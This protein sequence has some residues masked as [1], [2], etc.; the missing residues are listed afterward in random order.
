MRKKRFNKVKPTKLQKK[1]LLIKKE[2]PD[3]PLGKAMIKAGYSKKTAKAPKQNF[4]ARRGTQ[5]AIEKWREMLRE[6]G[7]GE[8]T[9][10]RKYKEWIDAVKIKS[11]LTEP[12][13]VVPDYETQL[14]V[15]DD[16]R[17]DLGL[18]IDKG[19]GPAIQVNV[20]PILGG[21]SRKDDSYNRNQENRQSQKK[22]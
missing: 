6:A 16:L 15:K 8:M 5:A 21:I 7:L 17:R 11:S 22:D 10:I 3:M 2:N 13:K 12:D 20:S 18:P 1:T 19:V 4:L 9:L 14:K